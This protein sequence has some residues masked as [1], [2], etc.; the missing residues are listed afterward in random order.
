MISKF[1]ECEV[2]RNEKY[3]RVIQT[4][5]DYPDGKKFPIDEIVVAD[6]KVNLNAIEQNEMGGFC[7]S[8]YSYIF[9]WLIRGDTLCEVEIPNDTKIYKTTSKNGIYIADKI[10]LKNPIKID[11]DYAMELY[12]ISTLPEKSYFI[13]MTVCA[14]CG[15]MKTALK[16]LEDKVT[17]ENVDIAIYELENFCKRHEEEFKI[18][19]SKNPEVVLLKNKLNDIKQQNR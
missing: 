16:V 2:N 6:R 8:K 17:K 19:C 10:I 4:E 5:K 15:Y 11:D 7:I 3:Y 18:D 1:F 12:K 9:R 13:A 14:I